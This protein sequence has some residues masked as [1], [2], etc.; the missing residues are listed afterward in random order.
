MA[1]QTKQVQQ[2]QLTEAHEYRSLDDESLIGTFNNLNHAFGDVIFEMSNGIN[3]FDIGGEVDVEKINDKINFYL[4]IRHCYKDNAS[5][6]DDMIN[7]KVNQADLAF[8][9]QI[10]YKPIKTQ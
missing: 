1:E 8:A 3:S 7:D 9:E 5:Y 4:A 10:G 6:T 2:T